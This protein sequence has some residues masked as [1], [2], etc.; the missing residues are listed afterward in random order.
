MLQIDKKTPEHESFRENYQPL[1]IAQVAAPWFSIP[2]KDYGGTEAV[3]SNLSEELIRQRHKVTLFASGDSHTS[4][5]LRYYI[6][7]S[8]T[9]QEIGWDNYTEAE[10]HM[11]NSF[12]EIAQ[13]SEKYDVVHTHLSSSS[14]LILF[15]LASQIKVPH[16]CTLHSRFLFDKRENYI[17][18]G[19]KYYFSWAKNTP[20][21]SISNSAK[22]DALRESGFPLN[23]IGVI[24]HGLPDN[25]FLKGSASQRHHLAWIGKI[26][27]DKGTKQAIEAAI[28]AKRKIILGGV[29]DAYQQVESFEY[30]HQEVLPLIEAYPDYVEYI[31]PINNSQKA[32]LLK[33]AY[34]FLN[35][36]QWE[37]PFGLVM[38]EAMAYGCPVIS[39]KRGAASEII[40]P[41]ING[42]F[43][44]SVDEMAS[45]IEGVG[46]NIDREKMVKDT[47]NNY[48]IS[49]IAKRYEMKYREVINLQVRLARV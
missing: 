3:I 7:E 27:R 20:I 39:F 6:E 38:I 14:D 12:R 46:N 30:F 43:A 24:P 31:G 16:I 5:E 36:I 23:F 10:Y 15:K 32:R 17:G 18:L 42:Q 21:I 40:K 48:S 22:E 1:R 35:P 9:E 34:C 29:V 47:W 25:Q 37:E 13:H 19:D 8:L 45:M 28:K 11:I 41:G 4:G 44:D 2:P 33:S 26:T 49:Y